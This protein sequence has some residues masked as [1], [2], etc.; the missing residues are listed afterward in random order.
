MQVTQMKTMVSNVTKMVNRGNQ[1]FM[2][3]KKY[4]DQYM[5]ETAIIE[6]L[7]VIDNWALLMTIFV[8]M[9]LEQEYPFELDVKEFHPNNS[10]NTRDLNGSELYLNIK[11]AK[12]LFSNFVEA[13]SNIL[14]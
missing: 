12:I 7:K 2:T 11:G 14:Q 10:I 13:I 1:V 9:N 4:L 3:Q 5:L 8:V 6:Q